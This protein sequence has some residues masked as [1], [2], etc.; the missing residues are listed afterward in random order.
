MAARM[1]MTTMTTNSST[2]VKAELV[3]EVGLF[4]LVEL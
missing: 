2:I 3:L 4:M 1:A